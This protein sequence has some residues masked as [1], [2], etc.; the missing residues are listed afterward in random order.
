MSVRDIE[1]RSIVAEN[2]RA[3]N[4][5]DRLTR[6]AAMRSSAVLGFFGFQTIGYHLELSYKSLHYREVW[7]LLYA[8][9]IVV[10]ALEI[11]SHALR[12][13]AVQ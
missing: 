4:R 6:N 2:P 8:L 1:R 7:T 13:S 5:R 12:R 9:L 10:W 3:E 11:W